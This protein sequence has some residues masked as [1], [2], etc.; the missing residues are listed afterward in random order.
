M[1][2]GMTRGMTGG[3]TRGMTGGMTGAG[4]RAPLV[5]NAAWPPEAGPAWS[6]IAA[7]LADAGADGIGLPDSPRLF[8]DPLITTERILAGTSVALAGP[9]VLSTGCGIPLSSQPGWGRSLRPIPGGFW[10]CWRA[11]R[12]PFATRD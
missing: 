12:V 7:P 10:P 3:M 2:G 5:V 8:P 11:A 9:C 4:S 6:E 1:T